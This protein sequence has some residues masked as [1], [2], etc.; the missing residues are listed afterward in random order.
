MPC[1][2]TFETFIGTW[3]GPFWAY[4]QALSTPSKPVYHEAAQCS[5]HTASPAVGWW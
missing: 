5:S 1:S 3:S 4:V 2:G